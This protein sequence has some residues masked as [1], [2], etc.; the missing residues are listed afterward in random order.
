MSY[1]TID[2][3]ARAKQAKKRPPWKIVLLIFFGPPMLGGLVQGLRGTPPPQPAIQTAAKPLARVQADQ[4][5][6][7]PPSPAA[8]TPAAA[9]TDDDPDQNLKALEPMRA[10]AEAALAS[11]LPQGNGRPKVKD[12]YLMLQEV[13][14]KPVGAYCGSVQTKLPYEADPSWH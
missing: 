8:S 7:S 1:P 11:K 9:Q 13:E 12:V 5:V 10:A 2:S 6:Q 14:G 4:Q 3:V